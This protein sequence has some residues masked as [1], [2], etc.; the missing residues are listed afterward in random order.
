MVSNLTKA[1]EDSTKWEYTDWVMRVCWVKDLEYY[2]SSIQ[3][4]DLSAE[5]LSLFW[6]KLWGIFDDFFESLEENLNR[7]ENI[8][9][10][11]L[12]LL[13]S[14]PGV[15]KGEELKA[16]YTN[17]KKV[18]SRSVVPALINSINTIRKIRGRFSDDEV[19]LLLDF[20]T[21]VAHPTA[22][23]YRIT[24]KN[25]GSLVSQ[26]R[27]R[28]REELQLAL[29][30]Q[31]QRFKKKD[32]MKSADENAAKY[33]AGLIKVEDVSTLR[34]NMTRIFKSLYPSIPLIL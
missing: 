22:N 26:Y 9:N 34:Q 2:L 28:D 19:L 13:D 29:A 4:G 5:K 12:R 8:L 7:A 6:I 21:H 24:L 30:R 10:F 20:R 31:N 18:Y 3:K 32:R 25:S 15:E 27:G 33:F 23:F 16:S 1:V 17:L 14:I 11:D